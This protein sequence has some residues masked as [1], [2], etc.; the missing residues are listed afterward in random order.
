MIDKN[1]KQFTRKADSVVVHGYQGCD[2]L[3]GA[4]SYPIYQTST[5]KNPGLNSNIQFSY[6]RCDNP[7]R[8]ELENTIALL[9]NGTAG[10][11]FASGLAAVTATFSL[12]KSGEHVVVSD[13]IYGGSYRQIEELWKN[14]GVEFTAVDV[15]DTA[16]VKAAVRPNT[17]MIYLE[18]PTNPMMKVADIAA[19]AEISKACG[20]L[21]VVDNTFLTP[22]FQ[23]PIELGADIVIHSG[24]KFLAGHHDTTAGFVVVNNEALEKRMGLI[25]RTEGSGLAPFDSWLVLRG[26]KTLALRMKRHEENAI[27]VAAFLKNHPAVEKVYFVGDKEHPSFDVTMK[28]TT[29]FG[30]MISFSI[31]DA[32]KVEQ[33]LCGGDMIMFAESLGGTATLI[34]YPQTQTHASIPAE[35]RNKIGITDRL[36]R[37]SVGIEDAEDIIADLTKM[38][39]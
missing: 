34:T 21:L 37:L 27:K 8:F 29:G 31:K 19:I 35:V 33:V 11:A 5:Y 2:P 20:A 32:S 9:E 18:S 39:S 24:T 7:T 6:S 12:L 38:L 13:D 14:F 10:Y 3:T 1:N 25:L 23:K 28:Q 4:I 30:G 36:I 17:K 15:G 22:Y 26:I 16:A